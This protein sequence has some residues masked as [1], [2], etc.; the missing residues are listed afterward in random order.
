MKPKVLFLKNFFHNIRR[1]KGFFI[2]I[3]V[4]LRYYLKK[5]LNYSKGISYSLCNWLVLLVMKIEKGNI[6]CCV[7]FRN[8][9][10]VA[11]A[12]TVYIDMT[13]STELGHLMYTA[14][15]TLGYWWLKTIF[16]SS[17]QPGLPEIGGIGD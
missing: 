6:R 8:S 12:S 3:L 11:L 14:K 13:P 9:R 10:R 17:S 7:R 15:R 1:E 16:R 2:E 5:N 4:K